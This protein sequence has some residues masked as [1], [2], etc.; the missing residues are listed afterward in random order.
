MLKKSFYNVIVSELPDKDILLYNTWTSA[1]GKLN[2]NIYENYYLKD[3]INDND[4]LESDK[5]HIL[6]MKDNGFLVDA[7]E[8]EIKKVQFGH[9]INRY[10]HNLLGLTIAPTLDC[11]MACKYCFEDKSNDKV[12]MTDETQEALISF[13]E[14]YFKRYKPLDF[15]CTWYGGE[16][17]L[18]L[19]IIEKLSSSFIELSAKYEVCYSS[20]IITNGVELDEKAV[21]VLR[22]Q[23]QVQFVQITIDGV[24]EI[25]NE[26]RILKSGDD[27][28]SKIIA[29]IQRAMLDFDI[30][31]RVNIDSENYENMDELIKYF[32][33]KCSFNK[34][35][36]YYFAPVEKVT[37]SC[38]TDSIKCFNQKEFADINLRLKKIILNDFG[39]DSVELFRPTNNTSN[40]GATSLGSYVIDP[41]GS[42]YNCWDIIGVKEYEIGNVRNGITENAKYLKWLMYD[43]PKECVE[44]NLLPMCNTGCPYKN[45]FNSHKECENQIYE[46]A[47]G[48]K[49]ICDH[50]FNN[51][52]TS[53]NK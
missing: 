28:F 38:K 12:Y 8:D 33:N 21:M 27:N 23:A 9:R 37:A 2:H 40:C 5:I 31:I 22:D 6:L 26:R 30:A 47:E 35:V 13:V 7:E 18:A 52:C 51:I 4:V 36:T 16:P 49:I 39:R 42:M 15:N 53:V 20:S 14:D 1:L 43:H 19:D 41:L 32:E 10:T 44:C 17:L 3:I 45:I 34:N 25:H 46:F 24:E 50:H 29:N 11:N 48:L